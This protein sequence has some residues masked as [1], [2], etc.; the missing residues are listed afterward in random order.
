MRLDKQSFEIFAK[1]FAEESILNRVTLEKAQENITLFDAP[2]FGYA[3]QMM[4]CL[5]PFC[6]RR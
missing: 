3:R 1:T 4:P 5:T 2:L 6:A